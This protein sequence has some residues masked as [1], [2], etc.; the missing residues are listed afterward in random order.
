MVILVFGLLA[1]RL[2]QLQLMSGDRY[3]RLAVAQTLHSIPISAERGSI[4]DRNGHDLALSIERPTVY[5]DPT[6]VNDPAAEAAKL[7]P[8]LGLDQTY[9][10]KQLT[11]RPSHFAYLAHTV[12]DAAAA[13]VKALNLPGIGFTTESARSYP[14]NGLAGSVLGNV[15]TDGTGLNGIE[16]LYNSM[17]D[18]KPGVLQVDEDP[19]GHDIP[20]TAKTKIAA[21]R[22]TDLV[23][24]IDEDLQWQ[25]EQSLLDQVQATQAKGGMAAVL[26][27]QTGD[28]LA[29]ATIDGPTATTPARVAT[30]AEHNAA[31]TD[32]FAPGSTTK[33]I[34]L[35]WALEH[36]HVA[37]STMFTVPYSIKV[38]PKVQPFYDAEWHS[39]QQWTTADILRESSN[40]GTIEIAQR[41]KNEELAD[42]VRAFGLGT[43]TSVP[44]PGQPNGLLLPPSQYYSTG[45][46][47]TAIGYGAAVTGLQMVDAFTTIANGG[48]TRP[49]RLL[50]ATIDA[51]GVRHPAPMQPGTRVVSANTAQQMT[52]MMEGVVSNGTGACAAIPGYPVAGKTGTSK[53]LDANGQYSSTATMASFIGFAPADHPRFAAIV[54]L[55]EPAL[56]FEFG[57][58]SAAPVWSEIMQFALTQYGV[59]P[60]DPANMQYDAS[61]AAAQY[62]CTV[63]HGSQL[64]TVVAN[65]AKAGAS[66]P[67]G[68]PP[69]SG[70]G[71]GAGAGGSSSTPPEQGKSGAAG[72]LAAVSSPSN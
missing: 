52:N 33:L 30:P 65:N 31:L 12:S 68:S 49:P 56:S 2:A 22:G 57:G 36:G 47:S 67:G 25:A 16:Y 32:L 35:S 50:D 70:S 37:P 45:K 64:Q 19:D 18:G 59:A 24:S 17:L 7:A 3:T 28:V 1:A 60:T 13:A 58:A 15:G 11:A 63:P 8:V 61:R 10:L 29:S 51:N 4:F 55:N 66:T 20:N 14:A 71:S 23:L 72:N 54:V 43:K 34:T 6:L 42:G 48:V 26:D 41:M 62:N 46:Y 69:H 27:V 53:T 44:W 40:V 21:H 39:T 38:D 5:A 9:L